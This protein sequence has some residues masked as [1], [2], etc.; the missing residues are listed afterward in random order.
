MGTVIAP[1]PEQCDTTAETS[2]W[3]RAGHKRRGSRGLAPGPL[4]PHFSGEMGTP[5]GQA[6]QR[7]AAP[8]GGF[9]AAHP[10]GTQYRP[11]PGR[12]SGLGPAQVGTCEVVSRPVP[13]GGSRL[14]LE[15]A[16]TQRVAGE[17]PR[18]PF[19]DGPLVG[20]RSFWR[21]CRIVAVEGLVRR[22]CMYPDLETFFRENAFQHIFSRKCV[23][24]RS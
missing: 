16:R 18:P 17:G 5:A 2:E 7:G 22:P 23:P 1:L 19:F 10:K 8:R 13:G 14:S 12:W 3:E 6:G 9:R 20:T 24:N 11:A 21:W 15:K 4:S